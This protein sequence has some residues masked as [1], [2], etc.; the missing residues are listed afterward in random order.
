[1]TSCPTIEHFLAV[2]ALVRR[3]RQDG[4]PSYHRP[5]EPQGRMALGQPPVIR[6]RRRWSVPPEWQ[7]KGPGHAAIA[8]VGVEVL[9]FAEHTELFVIVAVGWGLCGGG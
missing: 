4:D 6:L 8:R 3:H 1:M 5:E 2:I 9:V 7:L